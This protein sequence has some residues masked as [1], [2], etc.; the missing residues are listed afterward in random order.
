MAAALVERFKSPVG[1]QS[2]LEEIVL[3]PSGG[4]RYEIEV[5]GNLV[6]SKAATGKHI[7]NADALDL[8]AQAIA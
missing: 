6:Y 4:G 2:R 7:A 3:L 5:D 1:A 8:V